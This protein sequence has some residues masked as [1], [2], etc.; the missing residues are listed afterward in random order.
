MRSSDLG[1]NW[2]HSTAPLFH[3]VR[4]FGR[5]SPGRE[6]VVGYPKCSGGA[7]QDVDKLATGLFARTHLRK[8]QNQFNSGRLFGQAP[9]G[10]VHCSPL[11]FFSAAE[12]PPPLQLESYCARYFAWHPMEIFSECLHMATWS[13]CNVCQ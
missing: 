1:A 8:S 11:G 13:R 2:S 12:S 4:S 9:L 5:P 10:L 7:N 6:P 3:P